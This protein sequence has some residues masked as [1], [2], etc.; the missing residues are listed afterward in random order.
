MMLKCLA[1]LLLL[2]VVGAA[3]SDS[4]ENFLSLFTQVACGDG[5][6]SEFNQAIQACG[7]CIRLTCSTQKVD[8]LQCGIRS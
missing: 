3:S 6:Y 2:A 8:P 1:F 4:M 7:K 5:F